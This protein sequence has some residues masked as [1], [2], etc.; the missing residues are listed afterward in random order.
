MLR[1]R[2]NIFMIVFMIIFVGGYILF[3][4]SNLYVK[5]STQYYTEIRTSTELYDRTFTLLAWHY[6]ES[7]NQMEIMFTVQD[8]SYDGNKNYLVSAK[9]RSKGDLN[10]YVYLQ[11]EE[12]LI[13]KIDDLPKSYSD[14]YVQFMIDD[15]QKD[16]YIRFYTNSEAV[17]RVEAITDRQFYEYKIEQIE[18]NNDFYY[19]EI[20]DYTAQKTKLEEEVKNAN[21]T[22]D[23]LKSSVVYKTNAEITEIQSNIGSVMTD[24]ANME[25]QIKTLD[26]EIAEKKSQIQNGLDQIEE[27]KSENG[28]TESAS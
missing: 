19:S 23:D 11:N 7:Q 28:V 6:C 5:D 18:L 1:N 9:D 21:Q 27:I 16:S 12:L 10:A 3:F 25:N 20:D 17:D 24:I 22:V 2:K 14:I 15:D 26:S 4:T 8:M 13:V